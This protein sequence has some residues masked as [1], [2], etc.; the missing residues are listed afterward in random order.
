MQSERLVVLGPVS[1]A[2]LLCSGCLTMVDYASIPPFE[3][4]LRLIATAP[5]DYTVRVSSQKAVP[6]S[7]SS[8]GRI[9]FFVPRRSGGGATY[10]LKIRIARTSGAEAKYVFIVRGKSLIKKLSVSDLKKL[11][12]DNDGYSLLRINE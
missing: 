2:M 8:D 12:K 1:L 4:K 3:Q 7:V 6:L 10:L 9:T 11:P 5:E